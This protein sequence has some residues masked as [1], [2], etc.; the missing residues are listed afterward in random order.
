MQPA[1]AGPL[2]EAGVGPAAEAGVGAVVAVAAAVVAAAVDVVDKEL[3]MERACQHDKVT[4]A[5][6]RLNIIDATRRIALLFL[7]V[8]PMAGRRRRSKPTYASPEQAVEAIIAA[9]KTDDDA[10]MLAIFGEKHKNSRGDARPRREFRASCR[11]ARPHSVVPQPSG[12]GRGPPRR[13]T[14]EAKRGPCPFPIVR[15]RDAMALCHGRRRTGGLQSPHRRQREQRY[16]SAALLSRRAAA[17]TRTP[18][19]RD[20][21]RRASVTRAKLPARPASTTGYIGKR[22]TTAKKAPSDR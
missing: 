5:M 18:R 7:F 13:S 3:R 8:L 6:N 9:L 22:P 19:A 20:G 14:S 11:V 16:N 15:K 4:T 10:A 17:I 1:A 21:R 12:D 2:V